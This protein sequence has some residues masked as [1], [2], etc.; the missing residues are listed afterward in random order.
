MTHA[1]TDGAE[2]CFLAFGEQALQEIGFRPGGVA[3]NFAQP[4]RIDHGIG[5]FNLQMEALCLDTEFHGQDKA[6]NECGAVAARKHG[7]R[8]TDRGGRGLSAYQ[9]FPEE[10][11]NILHDDPD[12][13]VAPPISDRAEEL[14]A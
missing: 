1:I 10:F 14:P 6:G 12:R 13:C 7:H 5:G 4:I 2:V 9:S 11:G 8:P 3:A